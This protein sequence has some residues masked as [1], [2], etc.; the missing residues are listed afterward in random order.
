MKYNRSKIYYYDELID[1]L[2][3]YESN[4]VTGKVIV[5]RRAQATRYYRFE[6]GDGTQ[7][8]LIVSPISP[9]AALLIGANPSYHLIT[10]QNRSGYTSYPIMLSHNG[11]DASYLMEKFKITNEYTAKVL[12]LLLSHISRELGRGPRNDE[13]EQTD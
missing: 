3:R 11:K 4:M 13:Q 8:T 5:G 9:E 6:P 7:Y 10:F 2:P 1:H 12:S